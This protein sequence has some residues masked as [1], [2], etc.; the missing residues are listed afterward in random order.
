MNLTVEKVDA[1]DRPA[2]GREFLIV[3]RAEEDDEV[4]DKRTLEDVVDNKDARQEMSKLIRAFY[5]SIN[6]TMRDSDLSDT[7][8]ADQIQ[9]SCDQLTSRL[10][11]I[12]PDLAKRLDIEK[13]QEEVIKSYTGG[14]NNMENLEELLKG[15]EDEDTREA[16]EKRFE[17]LET[18]V[19]EL[20]KGAEE[21]DDEGDNIDKSELPE[22]VRKRI[23]EMEERAERAEKI[24]KKEREARR[25][26]EFKKRAK[27][28]NRVGSV[29]KIQKTLMKLDK[30]E[31]EDVLKDVEELLKSA[32]SR[33]EDSDLFVEKGDSGSDTT[34]ADSKLEKKAEEIQKNN[35]DL[36]ES[37]AFTEALEQNPDLYREYRESK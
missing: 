7:E 5:E 16:I 9:T 13:M 23:D 3:K 36:S 2:N 27:N 34:D 26:V 28:Y 32:Q 20:E 33:L 4:I 24:A 18:K 19:E 17:A 31:D 37:Q 1:V 25:E 29:E 22:S 10:N 11:D 14:E 12:A 6:E 30:S 15:I 21:N 8:K 35:P